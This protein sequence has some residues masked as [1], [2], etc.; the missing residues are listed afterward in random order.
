MTQKLI[1]LGGKPSLHN[2]FPGQNAKF[3]WENLMD[4]RWRNLDASISENL[5]I[6]S[7][8][9]F[10]KILGKHRFLVH[11]MP[12]RGAQLSQVTV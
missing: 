1:P 4:Y 12:S 10:D 11:Q 6:L 3:G 8:F 2:I 9:I 7:V 5:T